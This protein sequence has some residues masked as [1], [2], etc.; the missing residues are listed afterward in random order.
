[1]I[2]YKTFIDAKTWLLNK[3]NDSIRYHRNQINILNNDIDEINL[4]EDK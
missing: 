4:L 2:K 1:M 3:K